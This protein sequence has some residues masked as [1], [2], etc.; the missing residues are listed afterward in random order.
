MD[1]NLKNVL[2]FLPLKR[3]TFSEMIFKEQYVFINYKRILPFV[4]AS[5][6]MILGIVGM[7]T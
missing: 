6:K 4:K 7:Q 2:G 5:L 3:E 1:F